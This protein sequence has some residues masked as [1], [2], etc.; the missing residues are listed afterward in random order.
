[1]KIYV[2]DAN[3]LIFAC[4]IYALETRVLFLKK[5]EETR[6]LTN[7]ASVEQENSIVNFRITIK[8]G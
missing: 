6:V 1:M 4:Q 5:R 7:G 3:G 2:K 8:K